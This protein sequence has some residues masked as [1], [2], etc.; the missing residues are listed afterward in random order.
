MSALL[1]K[2]IVVIGGSIR[3]EMSACLSL[4]LSK[5]IVVVGG[6]IRTEMSA[7]LRCCSNLL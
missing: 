2:S 1:F 5:S 3:T 4:L 6:S 7:C